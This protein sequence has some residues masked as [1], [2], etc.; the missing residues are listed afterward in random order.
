MRKVFLQC[1]Y[2]KEGHIRK[3]WPSENG[4]KLDTVIYGI[5]REDWLYKTIT[6]VNWD[7]EVNLDRSD[8]G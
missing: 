8:L 4:Y 5:L 1:G 7:D 3:S 6:P 2:V